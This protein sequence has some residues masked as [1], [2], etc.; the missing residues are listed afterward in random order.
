MGSGMSA[1]IGQRRGWNEIN[2]VKRQRVF[3]GIEQDKLYRLGPRTIEGIAIIQK[4]IN[5]KNNE[6]N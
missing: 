2:A 5:A 3:T 1:E 6:L 4:C